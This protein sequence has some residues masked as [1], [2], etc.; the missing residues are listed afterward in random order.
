MPGHRADAFFALSYCDA[1]CTMTER[2][3]KEEV[4]RQ[5]S[6]VM[7][8]FQENSHNYPV[9][10]LGKHKGFPDIVRSPHQV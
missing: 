7:L 3:D 2:Q 10:A 6:L 9:P 4:M 1:A 8:C 5:Q